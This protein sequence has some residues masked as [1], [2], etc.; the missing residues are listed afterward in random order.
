MKLL[1]GSLRA[2]MSSTYC[3]LSSTSSIDP[4]EKYPSTGSSGMFL[5]CRWG[6]RSFLIV[7]PRL[8][9]LHNA[10]TIWK[11]ETYTFPS[12]RENGIVVGGTHRLWIAAFCRCQTGALM[13]LD[14][15]A[16]TFRRRTVCRN[17]K[18]TWCPRRMTLKPPRAP[19]EE[20]PRGI[21]GAR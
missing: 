17:P 15:S 3:W 16:P 12:T 21:W 6:Q 9:F 8:I 13:G 2:S 20:I 5:Q 1:G 19:R 7:S 11:Q 4:P 14:T 10:V 18:R